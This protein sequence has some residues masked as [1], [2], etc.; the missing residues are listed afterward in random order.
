MQPIRPCAGKMRKAGTAELP[1]V[2]RTWMGPPPAALGFL[3]ARARAFPSRTA[4]VAHALP[5]QRCLSGCPRAARRWFSARIALPRLAQCGTAPPH[6]MEWHMKRLCQRCGVSSS[7]LTNAMS[8]TLR[9]EPDWKWVL[10]WRDNQ[11]HRPPS[12]FSFGVAGRLCEPT[13]AT[14]SRG[15]P[16]GPASL[17]HARAASKTG[18]TSAGGRAGG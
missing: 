10:L 4:V 16:H 1:R 11:R 7:W 13:P 5:R 17:V 3:R 18:I 14:T 15:R 6:E 12:T 9:P 8:L 2:R